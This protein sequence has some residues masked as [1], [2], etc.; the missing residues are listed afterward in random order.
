MF[1]WF[2]TCGVRSIEDAKRLIAK[3]AHLA[4]LQELAAGWE[5]QLPSQSTE[6]PYSLDPVSILNRV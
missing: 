3:P 4:R 5:P 6:I 2:E 1:E